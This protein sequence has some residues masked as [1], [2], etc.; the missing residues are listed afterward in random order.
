MIWVGTLCT[1]MALST[2]SCMTIIE[3]KSNQSYCR[4]TYLVRASMKSL[5]TAITKKLGTLLMP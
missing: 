1:S 4:E 2:L 5:R 3:Q